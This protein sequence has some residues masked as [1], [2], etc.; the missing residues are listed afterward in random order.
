M[1]TTLEAPEAQ[2]EVDAGEAITRVEDLPD[3]VRQDIVA[4]RG[5]HHARR[6]AGQLPAGRLGRHS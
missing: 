1:T 3:E 6:A 2:H 5:G 4:A